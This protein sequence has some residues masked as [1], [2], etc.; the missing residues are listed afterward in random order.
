MDRLPAM[1]GNTWAG[2]SPEMTD[3]DTFHGDTG[4][5]LSSFCHFI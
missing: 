1:Y 4:N 5:I 3:V 2:N